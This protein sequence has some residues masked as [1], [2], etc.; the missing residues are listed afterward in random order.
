MT[1]QSGTGRLDGKNFKINI[2][3]IR[4]DYRDKSITLSTF[5]GSGGTEK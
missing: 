3:H 4:F 5:R 1:D 2:N